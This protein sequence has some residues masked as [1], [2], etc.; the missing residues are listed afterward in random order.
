MLI[1]AFVNADD[2]DQQQQEDEEKYEPLDM[3]CEKCKC[4]NSTA[5]HGSGGGGGDEEEE[6]GMIFTIDCSE[7]NVQHL[8][9]KWPEEMESQNSKL[10]FPANSLLTTTSRF[11]I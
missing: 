2:Y 8:F 1:I 10:K 9:N 7:K 5:L 3:A 6:N 11:L 4:K